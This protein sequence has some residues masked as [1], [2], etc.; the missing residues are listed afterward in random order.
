MPN[1]ELRLKWK[2]SNMSW[3]MLL[4]KP[5]NFKQ[6]ISRL[7]EIKYFKTLQ[8]LGINLWTLVLNHAEKSISGPFLYKGYNIKLKCLNSAVMNNMNLGKKIYVISSDTS[9][10]IASKSSRWSLHFH[11]S[12]SNEKSNHPPLISILHFYI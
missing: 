5:G 12:L 2:L 1:A 7:T 4:T 8:N 10:I 6:H 9:T 11:C 3:M